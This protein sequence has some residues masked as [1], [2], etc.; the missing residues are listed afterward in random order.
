MYVSSPGAL[1]DGL[2][3]SSEAKESIAT[4]GVVVKEPL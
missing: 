3:A 2:A 1:L 4:V